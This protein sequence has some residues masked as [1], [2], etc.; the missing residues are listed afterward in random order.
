[1]SIIFTGEIS[2]NFSQ[3]EYHGG[4]ANV[5]YYAS[6]ATFVRCLQQFRNW[7]KQKMYVVSWY[8]TKAENAKV[9]GIPNSNHCTGTAIDFHLYNKTID[10]ALFI[11]Y[12]TKWAEICKNNG[13]VGEAGLYNNWVH[14][15]MQNPTQA[16][17]TGHK[18]VHWD[19]RSG[20]QIMN[21]F[22]ELKGL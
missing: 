1:M 3:Q 2:K 19:S 8:R 10:K 18:F 7:L 12:A 20:K 4:S 9:G 21:P 6:T 22:S 15:G 11:K 16:I 13:C 14:L 5:C 17:S